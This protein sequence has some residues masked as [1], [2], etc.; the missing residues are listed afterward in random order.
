MIV[1]TQG[2]YKSGFPCPHQLVST[3][4]VSGR[5]CVYSTYSKVS[6]SPLHLRTSTSSSLLESHPGFLASLGVPH[7][8][9]TTAFQAVQ[10]GSPGSRSKLGMPPGAGGGAVTAAGAR[11][12]SR[13]PPGG[14][15]ARKAQVG[16]ASTPQR[17]NA[18]HLSDA[19]ARFWPRQPASLLKRHQI[20]PAA[21]LQAYPTGWQRYRRPLW[22][23][24][25]QECKLAPNGKTC[26]LRE[27]R[28]LP[29]EILT[30]KQ[31]GPCAAEGGG[32][33]PELPWV[34]EWGHQVKQLSKETFR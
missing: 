22:L 27:R 4:Q 25:E 17:E 9:S 12:C 18:G 34:L 33:G 8:T 3:S 7:S 14:G 16:V 32:P 23:G 29:Q 11:P 24:E 6:R 5:Q 30:W 13:P 26:P 31:D 21:P 20:V 28:S 19:A 10:L 2:P 15:A 1:W